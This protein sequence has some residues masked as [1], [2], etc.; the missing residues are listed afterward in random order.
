[1]ELLG[2]LMIPF[3]I[4]YHAPTT[5]KYS[6]F[7]DLFVLTC[8]PI[9]STSQARFQHPRVHVPISLSFFVRRSRPGRRGS[10]CKPVAEH[11]AENAAHKLLT[12][13]ALSCNPDCA[14]RQ[15]AV[16]S[17]KGVQETRC[18]KQ[19][20]GA[21]AVSTILDRSSSCALSLSRQLIGLNQ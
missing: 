20:N 16:A 2:R 4:P 10:K 18:L 21:N 17:V 3:S 9:S 6:S 8:R 13:S 15:S 1:M 7:L 12:Q 11:Q 19:H 14:E 5:S